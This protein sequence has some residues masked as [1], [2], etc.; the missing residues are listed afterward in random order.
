MFVKEDIPGAIA[1][2]LA[3]NSV[4][5]DHKPENRAAEGGKKY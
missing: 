1:E 5:K 3:Y 4:R 2:K